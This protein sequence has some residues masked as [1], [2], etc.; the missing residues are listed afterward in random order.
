MNAECRVPIAE[1]H[2]TT[3]P[4]PEDFEGGDVVELKTLPGAVKL[5][6]G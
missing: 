4:E 5:L 6:R 1:L 2:G 3:M